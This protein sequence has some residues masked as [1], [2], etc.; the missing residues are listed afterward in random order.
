MA[1]ARRLARGCF[2]TD[3]VFR[4]ASGAQTRI[5][6]PGRIQDRCSEQV[7]SA[8]R[9][10][11]HRVRGSQLTIARERRGAGFRSDR[12]PRRRRGRVAAPDRALDGTS[13]RIPAAARSTC[14]KRSIE[15][16]RTSC[17]T[18]STPRARTR[19]MMPR[20]PPRAH[21][22]RR[23]DSHVAC[24]RT[25]ARWPRSYDLVFVSIAT[26]IPVGESATESTS[27]RPCHRSECRSRQPSALS[28]L[29][30]RRTSSSERAPTRLRPAS[31]S[32]W[33]A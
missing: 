32:Q 22:R 9:T 28:G 1:S 30:A 18:S 20:A 31:A 33:R 19:Q 13:G 25:R 26:A 11:R 27:P 15:T 2:A 3:P 12:L 24:S 14:V 8:P 5:S 23:R 7:G 29:S 6:V 16:T 21:L 10:S 17:S 4:G